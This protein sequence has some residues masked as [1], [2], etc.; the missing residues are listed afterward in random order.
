ME[1]PAIGVQ[2]LHLPLAGLDHP[3]VTV[4]HVRH[5]VDTVKILN[6]TTINLVVIQVILKL[7]P[8][9]SHRRGTAP[10]PGQS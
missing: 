1:E 2:D 5:V 3:G 7:P 10:C 8:L 6:A 9:H 4:A